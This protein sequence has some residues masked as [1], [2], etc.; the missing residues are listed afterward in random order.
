MKSQMF[1]LTLPL[2]WPKPIHYILIIEALCLLLVRI[3]RRKLT[4][5]YMQE[6]AITVF[7]P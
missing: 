3:K 6:K 1:L 7:M 4:S 2:D 5:W